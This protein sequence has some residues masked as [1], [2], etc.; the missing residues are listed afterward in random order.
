MSDY[1]N[2]EFNDGYS[3]HDNYSEAV[4]NAAKA[5][6]TVGK[7]A[8]NQAAA[9]GVEATGRAAAAVVKAGVETGKA[10]SEIAVGTAAGGPWGAVIAAAWSARH[11]LFKIL[12]CICLLLVF[13]VVLIVS[14]PAIIFDYLC[15]GG[16]VTPD[17]AISL[18]TAYE[19]ISAE[20]SKSVNKGYELAVGKINQYIE[21]CG[22]DR[23][24]TEIVWV[25]NAHAGDGFDTAYILAA[26]SASMYQTNT[27]MS[28][29]LRKL[30]AVADEMYPVSSEI[31][32]EERI[33]P[34]PYMT[35]SAVTVT[36]VSRIVRTGTIN[37]VPQYRYETLP[38]T[39]Y[40]EREE[41]EAEETM[42]V[43]IYEPVTV[44][45]PV[46]SGDEIVGVSE[47]IYY[48]RRG[49]QTLTPTVETL[50]YL[51]CTV[52]PFNAAILVKAF[53]LDLN[54]KYGIFNITFGDVIKVMANTLKMTV[55]GVRMPL[56]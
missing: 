5:I 26:Y 30:D 20:V 25:D 17:K 40:I 31:R 54:A 6:Q 35:Y 52:E 27:T 21:D 34:V 47:E 1:Q 46:Y 48:Q 18:A 7:K 56:S 42:T 44:L 9:K 39:Y 50:T 2:G 10:V 24:G 36:V 15:S 51:I 33:T 32:T 3:G 19:E 13:F 38:L 43:G 55:Y 23:D 11:T 16:T 53:G 41:K 14:L 49:S 12:I 28:D 22:Y 29:M 37:G 4:R 45:I 8:A